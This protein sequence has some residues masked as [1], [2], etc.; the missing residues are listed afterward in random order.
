L[1]GFCPRMIL[2]ALDRPWTSRSE[3]GAT[4]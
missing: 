2:S 3:L 1:Y 4:A